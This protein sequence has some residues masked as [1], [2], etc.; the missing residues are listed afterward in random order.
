V[1]SKMLNCVTMLHLIY[2][3]NVT[4]YIELEDKENLLSVCLGDEEVRMCVY[5]PG[6]QRI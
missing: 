4:M 5:L 1:S 2:M 3:G 6:C